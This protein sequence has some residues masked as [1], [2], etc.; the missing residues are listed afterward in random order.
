MNFQEWKNN[1]KC[2]CGS[3]EL[4]PYMEDRWETPDDPNTVQ[5][6]CTKCT[7]ILSYSMSLSTRE[8]W[9]YYIQQEILDRIHEP[10][11]HMP[12]WLKSVAKAM[13]ITT[14]SQTP[15]RIERIRKR[16]E[17]WNS[18]GMELLELIQRWA[19]EREEI[20]P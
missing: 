7:L 17:E 1:P 13:K 10:F 8:K 11:Y 5:F 18:A 9:S 16:T 15:E 4:V 3:N 20:T 19:E 14:C 6:Q 2:S 12:E